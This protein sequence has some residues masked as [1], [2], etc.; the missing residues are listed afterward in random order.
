MS[1]LTFGRAAAT[2]ALIVLPAPLMAQ[3]MSFALG[4]VP[5]S[6]DNGGYRYFSVMTESGPLNLHDG[7]WIHGVV[8]SRR[9][10]LE[11]CPLRHE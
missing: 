2:I 11:E 1:N 5:A 6:I 7:P 8:R 10:S 3:D 9:V 4:E